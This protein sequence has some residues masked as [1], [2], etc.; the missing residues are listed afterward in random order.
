MNRSLKIA[1]LVLVAT[2]AVGAVALFTPFRSW[3]LPL[4]PVHLIVSMALLVRHQEW[5]RRSAEVAARL[6]LVGLIAFLVEVV[7]VHTGKIFGVYAYL[8]S[9]GPQLWDV[10]LIIGVNWALLAVL[11]LNII[12][13]GIDRP[14]HRAAV[15]AVAMTL[16][17]ALIEKSAP[18]MD[19]WWFVDGKVPIDN[20][21]GW[22][23]TG[24]VVALVLAPV[25]P[26]R[27]K[28]TERN[29]LTVGLW[30]AQLAFFA[31]ALLAQNLVN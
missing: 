21:I 19:M 12:P 23:I 30:A 6:A 2:Y 18:F 17:D 9:L 7:G 16:M 5:K 14:I 22:L 3:V 25:V 28:S 27:G 8:P 11:A 31:L 10:P 29:P 24:F 1:W 20:A 4:T 15:A 13:E 26:D